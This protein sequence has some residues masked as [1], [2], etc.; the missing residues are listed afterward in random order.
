VTADRSNKE[1]DAPDV[2]DAIYLAQALNAGGKP[3]GGQLCYCDGSWASYDPAAHKLPEPKTAKKAKP[4]PK[5]EPK[6]ADKSNVVA[7]LDAENADHSN[8]PL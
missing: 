5:P 4:E 2:E 1:V 7:K 8:L 6:P 3:V